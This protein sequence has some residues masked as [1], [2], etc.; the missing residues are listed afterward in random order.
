MRINNEL[1]NMKNLQYKTQINATPEKLW[2]TLW[3]AESY[4]EWNSGNTYNGNWSEGEEMKFLDQQN[5]G[6]YSVVE[7]NVKEKEMAM[8]H[9]GWIMNGEL[10]PQGW[11][12][13]RISYHL[14]PA[15]NGT[16][17][18]INVN[19]LDEFVDFYNGHIPKIFEKIKAIAER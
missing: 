12:D 19:A 16:E 18:A 4:Q 3:D 5:N 15:E 7:K 1:S 8:K 6:M 10:S 17:L 9:L 14:E 2:K 13:S 11:E